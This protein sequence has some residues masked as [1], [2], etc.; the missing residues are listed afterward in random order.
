ML[1]FVEAYL[2]STGQADLRDGAPARLCYRFTLHAFY[3]QTRYL[4]SEIG[5]HQIKLMS[6]VLSSRMHSRLRRRQPENQPTMARIDG[7]KPKDIS[8]ERPVSIGIFRIDNYMRATNHRPNLY[9]S[10]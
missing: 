2:S 1:R 8:K 6:I 5:A 3:L 7:P 10:A 9:L 4:A